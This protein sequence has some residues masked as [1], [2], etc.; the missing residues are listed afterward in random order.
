MALKPKEDIGVE[1]YKLDQFFRV[2][3]GTGEAVLN[4]VST[5]ICAGYVCWFQQKPDTTLS[6]MASSR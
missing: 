1:V 2:K 5:A 6:T 3:Q 4:G